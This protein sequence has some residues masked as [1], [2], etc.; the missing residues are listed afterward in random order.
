VLLLQ[1]QVKELE[2][3][4]ANAMRNNLAQAR[5]GEKA[6]PE[7]VQQH[8]HTPTSQPSTPPQHSHD[9]ASLPQ[10]NAP[11]QTLLPHRSDHATGG[12]LPPRS[13][14]QPRSPA[15][16]LT[17]QLQ[18]FPSQIMQQSPAQ[19]APGGWPSASP[20]GPQSA[21]IDRSSSGRFFE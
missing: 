16:A 7:R 19:M 20:V 14:A 12:C 17:P 8:T 9:R 3:K 11:T 6:S 13:P 1:K 15:A 10:H 5:L 21:I 4:H 2:K 18:Q